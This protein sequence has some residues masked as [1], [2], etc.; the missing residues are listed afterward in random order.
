MRELEY[1]PCDTIIS[2]KVVFNGENK[3]VFAK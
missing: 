1:Y 2:F 3:I